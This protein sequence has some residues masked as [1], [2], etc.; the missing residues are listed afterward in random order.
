MLQPKLGKVTASKAIFMVEEKLIS[1]PF[2]NL[3][4]FT[5]TPTSSTTYIHTHSV[6]G[7][8]HLLFSLYECTH[9]HTHTHT[10]TH[11]HMVTFYL[12]FSSCIDIKNIYT[13][14]C[15]SNT[16][17]HSAN[18][19]VLYTPTQLHMHNKH[20]QTLLL[21]IDFSSLVLCYKKLF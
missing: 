6:S 3:L 11:T 7:Q 20:I 17:Y 5:W 19:L 1:F 4:R 21:C 2:F 12:S 16:R 13:Q 18:I 10:L 8:T 9:T 15:S 14:I